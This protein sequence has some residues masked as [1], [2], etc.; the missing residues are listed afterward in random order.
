LYL[1]F[2][3]VQ[4]AVQRLEDIMREERWRDPVFQARNKV[5]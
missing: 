2:A 1:R 5:T 3:Y 4:E